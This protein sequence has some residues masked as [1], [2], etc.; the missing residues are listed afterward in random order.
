MILHLSL[1]GGTYTMDTKEAAKLANTIDVKVIIPTHY[2]EIVGEK[3]DGEEFA[4]Q[5]LG[6]QVEVLIK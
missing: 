6:K 1:F 2:G 5:V 3:T 4:K